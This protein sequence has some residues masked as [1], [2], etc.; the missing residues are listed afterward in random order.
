MKVYLLYFEQSD[1]YYVCE[2]VIESAGRWYRN[3]ADGLVFCVRKHSNLSGLG[4]SIPLIK[5]TEMYD[6]FMRNYGRLEGTY[7]TIEI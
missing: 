5:D 1:S 7:G 2:S 6:Y 4:Q 3:H